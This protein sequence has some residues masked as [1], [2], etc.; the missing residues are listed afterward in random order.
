VCIGVVHLRPSLLLQLVEY[1][2]FIAVYIFLQSRYLFFV[3][4]P[5]ETLL[6]VDN[7]MVLLLLYL[8]VISPDI[9]HCYFVIFYYAVMNQ[10]M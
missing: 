5:S 2:A 10:S 7:Q 6:L 4:R 8:L 9:S 1:C 3:S